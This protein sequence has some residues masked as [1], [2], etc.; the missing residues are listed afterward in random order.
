MSNLQDFYAWFL[1]S[2]LR[3]SAVIIAA[4]VVNMVVVKYVSRSMGRLL[5]QRGL[6]LARRKRLETLIRISANTVSIL[7]WA[8]A[9]LI[10]LDE[11][12]VKIGPLL[13]GAGIAGI[14]VGFGA[15]NM[16]RDYLSGLLI[17]MENQFGVGD[18]IKVADVAGLV[19]TMTLRITV[20]RDFEGRVHVIPNGEIKIL[21]NMTKH[22]SWSL[23]DIGVAYREDI[24]R[25][26]GILKA[27]GEELRRDEKFGPLILAP[28]E[29]VGVESLAESQV[30]VRCRFK[31][32]PIRQWD[33]GREFRRRVK[34]AF[35]REGVEFPFPHRK[36][37]IG[38]GEQGT[39]P[40]SGGTPPPRP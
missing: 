16:V 3:I 5:D 33:V 38:M 34:N 4:A 23:V 15:Q 12:R 2:G 20:L 9:A 1:G 24:D 25:V 11:L 37:Y 22:F 26:I 8:I 35:D 6:S 29:M 7:V 14:A 40:L 18:V 21:T 28:M 10:V 27:V 30:T 17:L 32:M 31:T 39:L 36:I 19:E 13:A